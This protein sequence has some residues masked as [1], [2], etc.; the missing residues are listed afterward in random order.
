MTTASPSTTTVP[1]P[2]SAAGADAAPARRAGAF[3][4]IPALPMLLTA[5]L[6]ALNF[7][8]RVSENPRLAGAISGVAGGLFVW[9]LVLWVLSNRR[10]RPLSITFAPVKSHWVQAL[11]QLSIIL[12]W[13]WFWRE[14]YAFMPLILAQMLFLYCLEGLITW[15]RGRTWRLGFGPM[16]II[17][18]TNLLLWFKD[19][20]FILQ[21]LMIALGVLGKQFITWERDG[22]RTHIFN[23]SAFGQSLIAL[24]LI[25]TGTT[26]DLT[27]GK[28]IAAT[29]ETP[30]MLV[31]IFFG[32]LV[33]QFLFHVTL[34]TVSA[35]AT[36]CI[37]N[38]L[39]TQVT[40]TYYFVTINIAAPIFL[41]MH[42]L[43]TD[44]ATSPRTNLGRVVFGVLYA[45]G[46]FVLFRVLD[47]AGV[48]TFWDKLLPVPVLNLLV[49][50]IDRA[51]R[52]GPFAAFNRAWENALR[53]ASLNLAHMGIWAAIF[54]AMWAT[55]FIEAPHPGNSIPFWKKALAEGKPFAGHSLVM[56]AGAQ[57]EGG[58]SGAAF[59]ELG[60]ICMEGKVP[61]VEQSNARAAK[62][63]AEGCALRD[64]SACAN[65]AVQFLFLRQWRS[66]EDVQRALALLEHDCNRDGPGSL[67]CY[68]IGF[69]HETGRGRPLDI[70]RAAEFYRRAGWANIPA[71]KGLARLGLSGDAV[72]P[73]L[74]Q[75]ARLLE[76][77]C[78]A[79]DVESCWYLAYMHLAGSGVPRDETKAR[80]L[81]EKACAGGLEQ[82]CA[83]LKQPELPPYVNPQPMMV[84][85]WTSAFPIN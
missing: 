77:M 48:P 37:L 47:L 55:G 68:L 50:V 72:L 43:M 79:G 76:G 66:D 4:S 20:W 85:G 25:A 8:P 9:E 32:G 24:V 10:A 6:F 22:R 63:F 29:F 82:A 58:R 19:D 81:L 16:P 65:V 49:P 44:P 27:W 57:A 26:N 54:F 21:F 42:L 35:V 70:G 83:A 75:A 69:A 59:N 18:S 11:V 13:G 17:L 73:E 12:Y 31:L 56:A 60:L 51:V 46:Y 74:A 64:G 40:G 38:I 33:V 62:Y 3:A 41:G 2:G 28:Q 39:F 34:M 36:L 78:D 5:G 67:S 1:H 23:P 71:I 7:L 52:A 45:V 53:P 14:V 84:P 15:S 61:G 80:T 30:H